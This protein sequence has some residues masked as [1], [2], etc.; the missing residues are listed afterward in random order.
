MRAQAGV[1]NFDGK[2]VDDTFL[3]KLASSIEQYG[4]DS[5][6]VYVDGSIGMVYRAFHTTGESQIERQP[7]ITSRRTVITWDGRL[8]NRDELVGQF[9]EGLTPDQTDVAVVAAAFERWGTDC[10]SRIV[11]DWAVSVWKPMERELLFACDYMCVRHIFYYLKRDRIWWSTDLAPLV[12]LSGDKF[13]IDDDYIAGYF[14]NDPD[15]HMTPYREVRQ[16]PAGQFIRIRN[17][18]L[19]VPRYWRFSPKSRMR[20]KTDAEYEEHFRH[21]F[22]QSVRRRLRS[23]SL[24][25]AE[26]SGGLDSSSIVCMADDILAKEGASTPRLDTLSYYD[27]TEPHGDDWIY[28]QK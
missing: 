8:D 17:D 12:L 15:S 24:I 11:G 28:F 19:M 16:V 13:H 20:Y 6:N 5:T 18:S 27:K 3:D 14:A 25:L 9:C 7:C 4:P 1:W 2:P 21:V 22:R 10:F 26:L 23:D